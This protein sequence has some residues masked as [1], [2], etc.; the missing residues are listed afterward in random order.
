MFGGRR[1][2]GVVLG[3]LLAAGHFN[4]VAG[5]GC[6]GGC[7]RAVAGQTHARAMMWEADLRRMARSAIPTMTVPSLVLG[8]PNHSGD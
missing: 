2:L 6:L 3:R 4:S 5:T 8:S 1:E 7:P